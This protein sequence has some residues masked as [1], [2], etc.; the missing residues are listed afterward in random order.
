MAL[1]REFRLAF[2]D[3]SIDLFSSNGVGLPRA[4]VCDIAIVFDRPRFDDAVRDPLWT[5]S[6]T[7]RPARRRSPSAARAWTFRPS[8]EATSSFTR[9]WRASPSASSGRPS[10]GN[11]GLD[12]SPERGLAL[13][14]ERLT[15][16]WAMTGNGVILVDAAMFAREIADGRLVIPYEASMRIRLRLLSHRPSRRHV[17]PGDRAVPLL[18]H[19]ALRPYAGRLRRLMTP[20][21]VS[22]WRTH[23]LADR[24]KAAYTSRC[25]CLPPHAPA[26]AQKSLAGSPGNA[27]ARPGRDHR[28]AASRAEP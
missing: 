20:L 27:P 11:F 3:I 24:S 2:P 10:P 16:E 4:T 15:V 19:P 1:L 6:Q 22:P 13:D 7:R 23:R 26:G 28:S 14:S 8:C 17:G 9:G 18:G 12:I 21:L 25:G 5:I